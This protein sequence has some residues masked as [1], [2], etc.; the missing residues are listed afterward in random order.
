MKIIRSI[1]L[2][3]EERLKLTNKMIGFVPTMGYFHEGHLSL[4]SQA[5]EENDI[6]IVSVFVNPLQFGP[7]ED[8]DTY[9]RDEERDIRLAKEQGVDVLFMPHVTEMYP[10]ELSITMQV[11]ERANALC[12]RSRPGHFDGVVTVL[13]KLFNLIQPNKVYV[14]MKDAQQVAVIDGLINDYNFPIKLIGLPTVREQSGLAKS[15]RNVNLSDEE[16]IEAIWIQ[17]ALRVG[18]Q[19][20]SD[21]E[22]R[23][24]EII[25]AV[26]QLILKETNGKIDYIELLS[27]PTLKPVTMIK[28][29]VILA[30]AVKFNKVRLIDNIIFNHHGIIMKRLS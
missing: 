30:T 17:K 16:R 2:M 28:Q 14:G 10:T 13:S 25:K 7:N 24:S 19:L 18:Q 12:G 5:K 22:V 26:E 21:G 4:M 20:V 29:N 11:G 9:P 1:K 23:S 27:Y 15:S 8:F 6:L 3:Q